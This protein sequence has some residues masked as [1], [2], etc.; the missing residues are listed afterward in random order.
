MQ[1]H[2]AFSRKWEGL[3][4]PF[5][6]IHKFSCKRDLPSASSPDLFYNLYSVKMNKKRKP[7]QSQQPISAFF[8]KSKADTE[9]SGSEQLTSTSKPSTAYNNPGQK[10]N[11]Q[12]LTKEDSGSGVSRGDFVFSTK[13]EPRYMPTMS[14]KYPPTKF[15]KDWR[16]CDNSWFKKFNW[17]EYNPNKDSVFCKPCR[18]FTIKVS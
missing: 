16:H 7:C 1:L 4:S 11:D 18:H 6:F 12:V 5:H 17:L 14:F 3:F 8:K 2:N 13:D 15:G 10:E 9:L